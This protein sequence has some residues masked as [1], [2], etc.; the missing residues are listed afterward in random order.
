MRLRTY[1]NVERLAEQKRITR[2]GSVEFGGKYGSAVAQIGKPE[3]AGVAVRRKQ[4]SGSKRMAEVLKQCIVQ[5]GA[6]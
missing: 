5:K 4:Q 1:H 3:L 6:A 2:A